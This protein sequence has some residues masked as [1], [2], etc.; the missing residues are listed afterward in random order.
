MEIASFLP[1]ENELKEIQATLQ[2]LHDPIRYDHTNALMTLSANVSSSSYVLTVLHVFSR[3]NL[4]NG[5]QIDFS[6]DLRRLAGFVLKNYVFCGHTIQIFERLQSYIKPELLLAL[7]D[8]YEDIQKTSAILLAKI[9]SSFIFAYW[10]DILISLVSNLTAEPSSIDAIR[11]SI[12]AL[13]GILEDCPEKICMEVSILCTILQTLLLYCGHSLEN[14]QLSSIRGFNTLLYHIH[15]AKDNA[16]TS[17]LDILVSNYLNRL[18]SL[19]KSN[20]TKHKVR[21]E[22]IYGFT[23]LCTMHTKAV[24]LDKLHYIMEVS[25]LIIL[26]SVDV[27]TIMEC[28]EFFVAILER[29]ALIYEHRI[30]IFSP[31]LANLIPALISRMIYTEEQLLG[32]RTNTIDNFS[33]TQQND[34]QSNHEKLFLCHRSEDENSVTKWTLRQ[35]SASALDFI[36]SELGEEAILQHALPVIE[37]SMNSKNVWIVES[38]LLALGAL[39]NGC[40]EGMMMYLPSV[41]PL[42]TDYIS[43]E[44]VEIRSV[45]CWVLSKYCEWF[46]KYG[47]KKNIES[48]LLHLC[49]SLCIAMLDHDEKVQEAACSALSTI[50][51]TLDSEAQVILEPFLDIILQHVEK[52]GEIYGDKN[53]LILC[54]TVAVITNSF[55]TLVN[56]VSFT[57]FCMPFLMRKLH[58]YDHNLDPLLIV[59]L[60]TF[61]SIAH[62]RTLN[63]DCIAAELFQRSMDMTESTLSRL[64]NEKFESSAIASNIQDLAFQFTS[65]E[66]EF[67]ICGTNMF[68]GLC[69]ALGAQFKNLMNDLSYRSFQNVLNYCLASANPEVSMAT[70]GLIGALCDQS[71]EFFVVPILPAILNSIMNNLHIDNPRTFHNATWLM[72]VIST[73]IAD[74]SLLLPL[75]PKYKSNM[76]AALRMVKHS[77]VM[78]TSLFETTIIDLK[79]NEHSNIST[80]HIFRS[81]YNFSPLSIEIC[82]AVA[83]SI[84]RLLVIFDSQ[85]HDLSLS[86]ITIVALCR[87]FSMTCRGEEKNV[88]MWGLITFI[89]SEIS[90]VISSRS[91]LE[92]IFFCIFS[93][94]ITG[95]DCVAICEDDENEKFH[96]MNIDDMHFSTASIPP[97]LYQPM[98]NILLRIKAAHNYRWSSL[99]EIVSEIIGTNSSQSIDYF[100]KY[101]QI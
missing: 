30:K 99:F 15:C 5:S 11:G 23:I 39:S 43:H 59:I 35:Q 24:G 76:F 16:E 95:F 34:S 98:R 91:A 33:F 69:V 7:R 42:L 79:S 14:I 17:L 73:K 68:E 31:F 54:D 21:K 32:E 19:T 60:E 40:P 82:S 70:F 41:L 85:F 94:T 49:S 44:T 93:Y 56:S 25:T 26:H 83:M 78:G 90:M 89:S 9:A 96:V 81:L 50:L 66:E 74:P 27:D 80:R 46:C 86:E 38:G 52:A 101:F 36:A 47:G 77:N 72:G 51:S 65:E 6:V 12:M 28:C 97:E 22:A 4:Y 57:S 75:I 61:T 53:S 62:V 10:S 2:A 8:P 58:E 37:I 13:E 29:S 45:T 88:A 92:A 67:I 48:T 20:E 55:G 18:L 100:L 64:R 1:G 87:T 71:Y 63:V 3:G 84:G